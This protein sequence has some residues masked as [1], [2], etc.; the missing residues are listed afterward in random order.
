[1]DRNYGKMW[2]LLC[3]R[4]YG[5][6][7]EANVLYLYMEKILFLRHEVMSVTENGGSVLMLL[8][9]YVDPTTP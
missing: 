8:D 3:W 5:G 1:M 7:L 2:R 4:R 6:V 9:Y